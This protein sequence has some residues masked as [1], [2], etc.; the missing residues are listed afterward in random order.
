MERFAQFGAEHQLRRRNLMLQKSRRLFE[1]SI[2]GNIINNVLEFQDYIRFLNQDDP[3]VLRALDVLK[4]G[5]SMPK[6]T[7]EVQG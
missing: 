6:A 1:R 2:Y 4:K 5:E 3:T 7:P